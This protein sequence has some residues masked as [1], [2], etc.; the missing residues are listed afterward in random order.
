VNAA[1]AGAASPERG[2]GAPASCRAPLPAGS[3][4]GV[5]ITDRVDE[6]ARWSFEGR[7]AVA[8]LFRALGEPGRLS[9]VGFIAEAERCG[10]ECR[11]HLGLSQLVALGWAI[12]APTGRRGLTQCR[13]FVPCAELVPRSWL[14]PASPTAT[15]SRSGGQ[16]PCARAGSGS[17]ARPRRSGS[18]AGR[19]S[20]T[21]GSLSCSGARPRG[22]DGSKGSGAVG[23]R[24]RLARARRHLRP[25]T[26]DAR[27][28]RELL[29]GP[30]HRHRFYLVGVSL[31]VLV[32]APAMRALRPSWAWCPTAVRSLRP[33]AA[34]PVPSTL[35][36][37]DS[38]D[39]ASGGGL[40][41]D[42]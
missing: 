8:S 7:R 11:G 37:W 31:L 41:H 38:S 18:S 16:A 20:P 35:A 21:S 42:R 36:R 2:F 25:L 1:E 28:G 10:T 34:D 39:G 30:S 3:P 5:G 29:P 24:R 13:H 27:G 14:L 22:L 33:L 26:G 19:A 9:L 12:A 40:R 32:L 4:R 6:V 15:R 17:R 23:E